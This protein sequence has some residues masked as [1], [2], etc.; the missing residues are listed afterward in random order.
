M[1]WRR[2]LLLSIALVS[3]LGITT[4][5]LLQN[6]QVATD[7][8]RRELK[9]AFAAPTE[10]GATSINLEAGR[11]QIR[12]FEVVDPTYPDRKLAQIETA[13]IDVQ[14]DLFGAG[15]Q[16]RHVILEGLKIECG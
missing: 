14:S 2:I 10:I 3:V 11:L 13:N 4:W 5:A 16:L 9:Q 7:F 6:S 8:V 12:D 15:V 1:N